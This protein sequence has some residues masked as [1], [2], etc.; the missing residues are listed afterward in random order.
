[1]E[2]Y[3]HIDYPIRYEFLREELARHIK[4]SPQTKEV[5]FS[6]QKHPSRLMYEAFILKPH[7]APSKLTDVDFHGS[8]DLDRILRMLGTIP[9]D[10]LPEEIRVIRPHLDTR[11]WGLFY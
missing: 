4:E 9:I 6:R 8:F 11:C 10:N 2:N 5:R 1:M 3:E 7:S